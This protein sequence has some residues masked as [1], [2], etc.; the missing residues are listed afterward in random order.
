MLRSE[1]T[2]PNLTATERHR[3]DPELIRRIVRALELQPSSKVLE[4]GTG[5]GYIASILAPLCARVISVE[6]EPAAAR[7]AVANL[8]QA[9]IETVEVVTADG[10]VGWPSAAPFDAILVSARQPSVSEAL[11]EQLGPG[12][13]L[14][15]TV[16][17]SRVRQRL[18]KIERQPSG[19]L[20]TCDLGPVRYLTELSEILL[21]MGA[22]EPSVLVAAVSDAA[23]SGRSIGR[24]LVDKDQLT[25]EVLR[26]AIGL[27]RGFEIG[28]PDRLIERIQPEAVGRLARTYQRFNLLVPICLGA[29]GLLVVCTSDP[30]V[31]LDQAV[32]AIGASAVEVHLLMPAGFER[33][34]QAAHGPSA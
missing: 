29:D 25:P 33:V 21:E 4:I 22:V 1:P 8:A 18:L 34:W 2:F 5:N 16:G 26:E 9:R 31:Q 20:K 30:E 19:A 11:L 23:E 27:Q 28:D 7:W 12:G 32:Q 13:R 17:L 24:V 14:V 6:R 10:V 15:A 3:H